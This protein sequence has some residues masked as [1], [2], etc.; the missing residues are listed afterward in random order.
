MP[1]GHVLGSLWGLVPRAALEYDR[2]IEEN[3]HDW[4]AEIGGEGIDIMLADID[5]AE[6]PDHASYHPWDARCGVGAN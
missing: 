3:K 2:Q 1:N 6:H 4:P 5:E